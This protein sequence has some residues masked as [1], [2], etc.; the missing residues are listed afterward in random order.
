V[1]PVNPPNTF[2]FIQKPGTRKH[3][4]ACGTQFGLGPW[5]LRRLASGALVCNASACAAAPPHPHP[6]PFVLCLLWEQRGP[7]KTSNRWLK[8]TDLSAPPSCWESCLALPCL[9]LHTPAGWAYAP[10]CG[11]GRL[12]ATP[13]QWSLLSALFLCSCRI[14]HGLRVRDRSQPTLSFPCRN[15]W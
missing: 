12:P 10:R 1:N 2:A 3:L 5:R 14:A 6:P 15:E 9:A 8:C 13:V 4:D 11:E 7:A